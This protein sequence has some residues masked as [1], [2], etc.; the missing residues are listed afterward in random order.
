MWSMTQDIIGNI[1]T[2]LVDLIITTI[3]AVLIIQVILVVIIIQVN[4]L[5]TVRLDTTMDK[6]CIP[7]TIRIHGSMVMGLHPEDVNQGKIHLASPIE[8]TKGTTRRKMK[9]V[10]FLKQQLMTTRQ[11][12]SANKLNQTPMNAWSVMIH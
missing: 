3:L 7:A 12:H 10:R 11:H 4:L 5:D 6:I 9:T 1:I 8:E 2:I